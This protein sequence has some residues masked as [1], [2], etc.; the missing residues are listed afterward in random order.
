MKLYLHIG[1]EKTGSSFLQSLIYHNKTLLS[2]NYRI[3]IPKDF[4]QDRRMEKGIISG[5]NG[6]ELFKLLESESEKKI[7]DYLIK[8]QKNAL[9]TNY[10]SI[11][12]S[13]ENLFRVLGKRLKQFLQ[14]CK[15]INLDVKF[16][17]YLRNPDSHIISMYK[18]RNKTG[19]YKEIDEWL[20]DYSTLK[21]LNTFTEQIFQLNLDQNLYIYSYESRKP[22]E[23]SFFNDFLGVRSSILI[24]K[25]EKVNT[26]LTF[27]EIGVLQY[28][29][30]KNSLLAGQLSA[31]FEKMK[32]IEKAKDDIVIR[33]Y[34]QY[35]S[36]NYV[37]ENFDSFYNV[38]NKLNVKFISKKELTTKMNELSKKKDSTYNFAFSLSTKQLELILTKNNIQNKFVMLVI[39]FRRNFI[40]PILPNKL[41][42]YVKYYRL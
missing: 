4:V 9:K 2:D 23:E 28:F 27:S 7:Q 31:C 15:D 25:F 37:L 8:L 22:L 11:L 33:E 19:K 41:K 10:S 42:K 3:Y 36:I 1:T 20:K 39:F 34:H 16:C 21:D 12:L 40:A 38:Y 17:L 30:P 26:S 5:G 24:N 29:Y 35:K 13:N 18:H 14:L 6:L 32:K